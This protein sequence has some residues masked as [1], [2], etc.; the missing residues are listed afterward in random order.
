MN[1]IW[2]PLNGNYPPKV[3]SFFLLF[4]PSLR[5]TLHPSQK[6]PLWMRVRR[7]W[8]ALSLPTDLWSSTNTNMA[9]P[10]WIPM[11]VIGLNCFGLTDVPWFS[12]STILKFSLKLGVWLIGVLWLL[13]VLSHTL[14]GFSFN[15]VLWIS[16]NTVLWVSPNTGLWVSHNTDLW[17]S[18]IMDL[19][20]VKLKQNC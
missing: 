7:W 1:V 10:K 19:S 2:P 4:M 13:W 16:L 17:V 12:L 9:G 8:E 18:L 3:E 14:R 15:A 20:M 6:L 11:V 5:S